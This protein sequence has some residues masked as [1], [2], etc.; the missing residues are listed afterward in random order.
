VSTSNEQSLGQVFQEDLLG[1]TDHFEVL[2]LRD[3]NLPVVVLSKD[4]KRWWQTTKEVMDN[5][6]DLFIELQMKTR[7]ANLL[8][9]IK[10]SSKPSRVKTAFSLTMLG[11]VDK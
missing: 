7:A 10:N 4:F 2:P 8:I 6:L 11:T 9:A 5:L 3:F 1:S